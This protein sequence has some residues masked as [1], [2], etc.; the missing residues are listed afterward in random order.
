MVSRLVRI[1]MRGNGKEK[2]SI[3]SS[4]DKVGNDPL[5]WIRLAGSYPAIEID[6]RNEN[7]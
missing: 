3:A 6:L 4:R 7:R 5:Y 1:L 2:K